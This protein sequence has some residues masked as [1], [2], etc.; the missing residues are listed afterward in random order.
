MEKWATT[1][2]QPHWKAIP[3]ENNTQVKLSFYLKIKNADKLK[4][5]ADSVS[6]PRSPMYG[7]YL[8][9]AEVGKIVAPD[10]IYLNRVLDLLRVHGANESSIRVSK[11]R[12]VVRAVVSLENAEKMLQCLYGRFK[13]KDTGM[14]VLRA[15]EGY[16]LPSEVAEG[17]DF[18]AGVVGF[19]S[20]SFQF[21]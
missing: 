8:T 2:V 13:H 21:N 19:P 7:K 17:V 11:M 20:M 15:P 12:D 14:I 18:V 10:A 5:I 16:S 6:N 1:N 4:Q 3:F 9:F